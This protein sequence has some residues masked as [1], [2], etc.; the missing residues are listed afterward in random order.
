[1]APQT[2]IK[3]ALN[4]QTIRNGLY[5]LVTNAITWVINNEQQVSEA[6]TGLF[7]IAIQPFVPPFA[8]ALVAALNIYFTGRVITGRTKIG[9]IQGLYKKS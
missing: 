9:D 6:L 7:P 1:M 3:G 5:L 4:S 8:A 2:E